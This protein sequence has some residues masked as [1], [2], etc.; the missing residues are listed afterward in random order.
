M[1]IPYS[2]ERVL[3]M[4]LRSLRASGLLADDMSAQSIREVANDSTD[5]DLDALAATLNY[6][7]VS[8]ITDA[9]FSPTN[10]TVV[11]DSDDTNIPPSY[12]NY[13]GV[14][15]GFT[16]LPI[17]DDVKWIMQA[18]S[19]INYPFI[20]TL[21]YLTVGPSSVEATAN[22]SAFF[23][24]GYDFDNS[25]HFCQV[26]SGTNATLKGRGCIIEASEYLE[27][28]GRSNTFLS[29]TTRVD[30]TNKVLPP[31]IRG[32]FTD[33]TSEARLFIGDEDTGDSLY[34]ERLVDNSG[35]YH[36]QLR[37]QETGLAVPRVPKIFLSGSDA[38]LDH[39]I[40]VNV[41]GVMD[42]PTDP[43]AIGYPTFSVI[44]NR[45]DNYPVC[46]FIFSDSSWTDGTHA[47]FQF[48]TESVN[49]L[50]THYLLRLTQGPSAT[51]VF[52]IDSNGNANVATGK[53]YQTAGADAA[54]WLDTVADGEDIP[55]GTVLV[56]NNE[57]KLEPSSIAADTRVVGVV[58]DTAGVKLGSPGDAVELGGVKP[59]DKALVAAVGRVPVRCRADNGSIH[60]G[61][62][63]VSGPNG[64]AVRGESD[65]KSAAILGK[66]IGTHLEGEG[67]VEALVSW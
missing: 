32:G 31:N 36:Y 24:V 60:P 26:R 50:P 48:H 57:G 28:S 38:G 15:R 13:F 27:L 43:W 22:R 30:F 42:T 56:I 59:K 49:T 25:T 23:S 33:L 2:T 9:I 65:T 20:G 12:I 62:L 8:G 7:G 5:A 63:L 10:F 64:C 6:G 4:V 52:N 34:I 14:A 46:K 17:T 35:A 3:D 47:I 61:D 66:S 21:P 45:G 44:G 41:G 67:T 51:G 1:P 19:F 53:A 37:P 29:S 58:S 18:G 11:I 54:E 55:V 40:Y 39:P 16:S